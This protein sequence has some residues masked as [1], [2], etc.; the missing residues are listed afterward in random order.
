[1]AYKLGETW[2]DCYTGKGKNAARSS[3]SSIN[4]CLVAFLASKA[5]TCGVYEMVCLAEGMGTH[6]I[7]ITGNGQSSYSRRFTRKEARDFLSATI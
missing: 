3:H 7:G 5:R 1:M 4:E 2:F 6:R